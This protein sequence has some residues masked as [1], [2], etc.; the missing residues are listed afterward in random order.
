MS[1]RKFQPSSATRERRKSMAIVFTK[2]DLARASERQRE[3]L[4]EDALMNGMPLPY[5]NPQSEADDDT[6]FEEFMEF[7]TPEGP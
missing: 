6:F 7:D 3:T 1:V 4:R 5:D 2:D